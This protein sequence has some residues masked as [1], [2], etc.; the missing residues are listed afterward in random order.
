MFHYI[1]KASKIVGCRLERQKD[2]AFD[3]HQG[4]CHGFTKA[5]I[6]Y[7]DIE[8]FHWVVRL[9]SNSSQMRKFFFVSMHT[10]PNYAIRKF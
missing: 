5:W 1:F 9:K 10:V 4:S 7:S 6:L 3:F 8:D 2:M